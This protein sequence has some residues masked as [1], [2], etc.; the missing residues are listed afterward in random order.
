MS[1]QTVEHLNSPI[2]FLKSISQN[3][4]CNYF[5]ITVPYIS[6]SRIGLEHIRGNLDTK[7]HAENIHIFEL[8]PQDW[9]LLFK[10]S[11]WE[12]VDETVYFQY[13]KNI[14]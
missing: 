9:K 14:F 7:V 4:N 6:S 10:H 3:T 12:I 2:N 11:G 1:F 8:S 13:P 5:L